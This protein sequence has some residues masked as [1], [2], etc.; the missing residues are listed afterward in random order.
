MHDLVVVIFFFLRLHC[1]LLSNEV[2]SQVSLHVLNCYCIKNN[3]L[4]LG[5]KSLVQ[6]LDI[7]RCHVGVLILF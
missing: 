2:M 3:S 5:L 7:I 6:V 1:F 4:K